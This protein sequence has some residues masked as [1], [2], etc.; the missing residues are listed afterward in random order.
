MSLADIK[1]AQDTLEQSFTKRMAE[2][3]AQLHT[4][5][6]A[7]ETVAK[8][9]EEFRTFRELM[10]SMLG[11]L[12]KQINECAQAIDVIETRHR[13][14]A[15]IFHGIPEA[16]GEQCKAVIWSIVQKMELQNVSA[17]GISDCHRIGVSSKNHHRP[18]LVWFSGVD[19]RSAVWRAKAKLKGTAASVKEFLTRSRQAVFAKAR[20]HFGMRTCWTQDGFI[21]VKAPD[22]SRHKITTSDELNALTT[23]Y[24]KVVSNS[25]STSQSG[26]GI[27]GSASGNINKPR[28]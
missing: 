1:T 16:D 14:K 19:V 24:A 26:A 27:A 28:K 9:A 8:V 13:R 12:R 6:P 21:V 25:S 18:I 15:L 5:G 2:L 4:G 7:K 17:A 20:Q 23:K 10:F 22:A 11:L 3:E